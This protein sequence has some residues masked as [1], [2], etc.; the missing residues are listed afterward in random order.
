MTPK[1]NKKLLLSASVSDPQGKEVVKRKITKEANP[2]ELQPKKLLK[3]P[4]ALSD[5][6]KILKS[7]PQNHKKSIPQR[8]DTDKNPRTLKKNTTKDEIN[9]FGPTNYGRKVAADRKRLTN[10]TSKSTTNNL[11]NTKVYASSMKSSDGEKQTKLRR[12]TVKRSVVY[13]KSSRDQNTNFAK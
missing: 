12:L 4:E 3:K 13:A 8:S 6:D 9:Q 2:K 11:N 10:N 5:S 7:K 1:Q